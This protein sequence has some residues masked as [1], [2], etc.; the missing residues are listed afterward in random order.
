MSRLQRLSR[1][2]SFTAFG[3]GASPLDPPMKK[4]KMNSDERMY[5]FADVDQG[6]ISV[7]I[8]HNQLVVSYGRWTTTFPVGELMDDTIADINGKIGHIVSQHFGGILTRIPS[9]KWHRVVNDIE[10]PIPP[11]TSMRQ[12]IRWGIRSDEVIVCKMAC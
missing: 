4:R 8:N 2:R 5:P 10:Y 9:V 11:L 3:G 7:G 1:K 6:P 12:L